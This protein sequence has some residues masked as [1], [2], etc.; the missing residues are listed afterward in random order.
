MSGSKKYVIKSRKYYKELTKKSYDTVLNSF[1]QKAFRQYDVVGKCMTSFC[2]WYDETTDYTL[3]NFIDFYFAYITSL[4]CFERLASSLCYLCSSEGLKISKEECLDILICHA[5]V[6]TYD[7]GIKENFID[8]YIKKQ[9]GTLPLP[10]NDIWDREY[11][12]DKSFV[13]HKRTYFIQIKPVSFFL[14]KNSETIKDRNLAIIKTNKFKIDNE[15]YKDAIFRYVIYDEREDGI[16]FLK[17]K[18]SIFNKIDEKYFDEDV[19]CFWNDFCSDKS[20][21]EKLIDF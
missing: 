11:G 9:E 17:N 16:Y 3:K 20:L 21:W 10:K 1:Y 6:E 14:G 18:E 5:I 13:Y 12:I 8:G 15:E 4:T 19:K 7:G 2:K